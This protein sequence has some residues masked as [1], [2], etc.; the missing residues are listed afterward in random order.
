MYMRMYAPVTERGG[1]RVSG[2]TPGDILM[3]VR[4]HFED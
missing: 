2:L 4:T 1:G 3:S